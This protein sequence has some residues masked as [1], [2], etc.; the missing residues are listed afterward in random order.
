M[1]ILDDRHDT[2]RA[3]PCFARLAPHQVTVFTDHVEDTDSARAKQ[4]FE[5]GTKQ[6]PIKKASSPPA[7]R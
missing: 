5:R 3:L 1:T 7:M 6:S 2:L 4:P